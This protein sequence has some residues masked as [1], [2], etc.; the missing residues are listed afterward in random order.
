[1]MEPNTPSVALMLALG[2]LWTPE[3]FQTALGDCGLGASRA[4]SLLAEAQSLGWLFRSGKVMQWNAEPYER[5]FQEL[6][7]EP[8]LPLLIEYVKKRDSSNTTLNRWAFYRNEPN[9]FR[10]DGPLPEHLGDDFLDGLHPTLQNIYLDQYGQSWLETGEIS[11]V[12][13]RL[14]HQHPT[15]SFDLCILEG[16]HLA[17]DKTPERAAIR[18]LLQGQSAEAHATFQGILGRKK[19][20]P[21]WTPLTFLMSQ[22]AALRQLDLHAI[23]DECLLGSGSWDL[24]HFMRALAYYL[25]G[26]Q[27]VWDTG[28]PRLEGRIGLALRAALQ[29]HLPEYIPPLTEGHRAELTD[30]WKAQGLHGLVRQL[31]APSGPEHW[32]WG[33]TARAGWENWLESLR[34]LGERRR[35]TTA[36]ARLEKWRLGWSID[37]KHVVPLKQKA[38]RNGWSSQT[39]SYWN[40]R[41]KTP[42]YV[43]EQDRVFMGK[44]R[45]GSSYHQAEPDGDAW[46]SLVG[47]PHL[48]RQGEPV[49]LEE[50]PLR[51]TVQETPSGLELE[52]EPEG[53]LHSREFLLLELGPGRL[54][55][56][57][58]NPLQKEFL[59]LLDGH[60]RLPAEA[61]RRLLDSLEPWIE[62]MDLRMPQGL[63]VHRQGES[64]LVCRV[65][66]LGE[67]LTFDLGAQPAGPKG[68]FVEAGQGA[69]Q[70]LY[71]TTGGESRV[72]VR[73]L[74]AESRALARL[75]PHVLPQNPWQ[76]PD[77]A[78][79]L[80][81]LLT[82]QQGGIELHW[83]AGKPWSVS[84][85]QSQIRLRAEGDGDW[86]EVRGHVALEDG[87]KL[88]IQQLLTLAR[89]S[90]GRFIKLAGD[91]FVALS[92]ELQQRLR[93]L[94]ELVEVKHKRALLN[95]L[96]ARAL[97]DLGVEGDDRFR[98][99]LQAFQEADEYLAATPERLLV[100]LRDYQLEGFR[101]LARRARAGAGCC[102]A[103]DMGLGKTLQVLAL[104]LQESV[105]GP[106]LVVCPTSV[107]SNWQQQAAQFAPSLKLMVLEGRGRQAQL[108]RLGPGHIALCSYG[109]LL[110]DAERLAELQWR[111]VILDEAQY[112]K[113]P[114]SKTARAACS[115]PADI[116]VATTG[117]PVENRLTELWSLFQFLNP[118]LL[119]SL[120]GFQKRFVERPDAR[121][122]LRRLVAPFLLRRLKTQVL[123]ELPPRTD[124]DLEVELS[125]RER[126]VYE[127]LRQQA[128]LS[129]EPLQLL[130][131]LMKLR[132]ACCH[133]ALVGIEGGSSKL[134]AF[135][136]LAGELRAGKHRVLVFS[137]FVE[138]L[139]LLR[140]RLEEEDW[141]YLYLDGS[142]PSAQRPALVNEF[143]RGETE[144]FL[145]SLK[146]GGTG[147]NLTAADYVV[148]LDPWWN[149][150]VE[151]QASDRAHRLGQTRPV[152][153]YRL[154][155]KDTLE[156]RVLQLHAHKRELARTVLDGSQDETRLNAEELLALLAS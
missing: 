103:D 4:D 46:S 47:H 97:S 48:Y 14:L 90:R 2:Q 69:E 10:A 45:S 143:Q 67:G 98:D 110:Q 30:L 35:Q 117:T 88:E 31:E 84:A 26:E 61:G 127:T 29:P 52:V 27:D 22:L 54:G 113:N 136:Q 59:Q 155:A 12:R 6:A 60:R 57:R 63:A 25:M 124:I 50:A 58:P 34:W 92:E 40:L 122:R 151:D 79:A 13:R 64:E 86:F 102:L 8:I 116:R 74:A 105:R 76:A 17:S 107:L 129:C 131:Q 19:S 141:S 49:T 36:R 140:K 126:A 139:Q 146:A 112:I 80:E 51:L 149:P 73:D 41:A 68:P 133:P 21:E 108:E 137:Q 71:R 138:L 53:L 111:T 132:Q 55:L 156:E 95:R 153:V 15:L 75:C 91:R 106:Q 7:F 42:S 148:H 78:D 94:D 154:V 11:L 128:V 100:E 145:I 147:L 72:V 70:L 83:P 115:L 56:C 123:R 125:E 65:R 23:L 66:P 44:A 85:V 152:T 96:A 81:M 114:E 101:W 109:I 89:S 144:F 130:A 135:M 77:P 32:G 118:G 3:S 134:E 16:G 120:S 119:G 87:V 38:G 5:L 62:R 99:C 1:M 37:G 93:A 150:A 24:T 9:L 28:F 121:S 20:A 33:L 142:T 18:M 43:S 82:L 39:A 104:L